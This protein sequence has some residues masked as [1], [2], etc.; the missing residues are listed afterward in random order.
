MFIFLLLFANV[1]IANISPNALRSVSICIGQDFGKV[2]SQTLSQKSFHLS[3]SYITQTYGS[4]ICIL[5]VITEELVHI[6][7]KGHTRE[8]HSFN[9]CHQYFLI[10]ESYKD[11]SPKPPMVTITHQQTNFLI[12]FHPIF[13]LLLEMEINRTFNKHNTSEN[14]YQK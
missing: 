1:E 10:N 3:S 5:K 4:C 13:Q 6:S 14:L 12:F 11:I 8:G 9:S 2:F 7:Y